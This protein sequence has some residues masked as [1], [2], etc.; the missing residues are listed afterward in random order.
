M[1]LQMSNL[2][3]SLNT[4]GTASTIATITMDVTIKK[5]GTADTTMNLDTSQFLACTT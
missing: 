4:S 1:Q 2:K 5:W 3:T